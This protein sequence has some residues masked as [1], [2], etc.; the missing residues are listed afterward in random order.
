MAGQLTIF[1]QW[2]ADSAY[3]F[4]STGTPKLFH[5]PASLHIQIH[6]NL[7]IYFIF[8]L[9]F[10]GGTAA[11]IYLFLKDLVSYL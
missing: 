5:L 11:D 3:P 2:G 7:A 10:S 8:I 4:I 9:F 1:Q 6:K